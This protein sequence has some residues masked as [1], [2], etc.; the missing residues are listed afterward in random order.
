[1]VVAMAMQNIN[2]L[3]CLNFGGFFSGF[4]QIFNWFCELKLPLLNPHPEGEE[5]KMSK[6]DSHERNMAK[7]T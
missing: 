5:A 4:Q 6:G 2:D 3:R 1:M 7:V